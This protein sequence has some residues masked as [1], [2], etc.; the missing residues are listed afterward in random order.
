M[1][2]SVFCGNSAQEN[3][4]PQ[5]NRASTGRELCY[6]RH[7]HPVSLPAFTGVQ[8]NK[9][10]AF[11]SLLFLVQSWNTIAV[12]MESMLHSASLQSCR[13]WHMALALREFH[14]RLMCLLQ[15]EKL[16]HRIWF[17][18]LLRFLPPPPAVLAVY[19]CT[20]EPLDQRPSSPCKAGESSFCPLAEKLR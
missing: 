4:V 17:F 15:R 2:S 14:R 5:T 3:T 19:G 11:F 6:S 7:P 12:L 9:E 18:F 13:D 1:C 8:D 20:A 10:P 16:Q